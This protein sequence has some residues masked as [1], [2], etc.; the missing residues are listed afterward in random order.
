MNCPTC[1][2]PLARDGRGESVTMLGYY[3]PTG[4]RHDDNC[5]KRRYACANG[6]THTLSI[7]NRCPACDWRGKVECFCSRKVEEW[8]TEPK[9]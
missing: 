6:H 3:S 2:E 8:P 5:R 1:N 7:I 4:H 9:A